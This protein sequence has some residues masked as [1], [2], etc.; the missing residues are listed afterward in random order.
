MVS[1]RR[2]K[3]KEEEGLYLQ[4][5]WQ[6]SSS[7][8]APHERISLFFFETSGPWEPRATDDPPQRE[9]F[10]FCV[11]YIDRKLFLKIDRTDKRCCV[12]NMYFS[13]QL[14][15]RSSPSETRFNEHSSCM[16]KSKG[17]LKRTGFSEDFHRK[18]E[19]RSMTSH[20]PN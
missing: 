12:T 19:Y 3:G 16:D 8:V 15:H 18:R 9:P 7:V 17:L 13:F 10:L 11:A 2:E 14:I 6:A 1:E 4:N 5:T 20:P